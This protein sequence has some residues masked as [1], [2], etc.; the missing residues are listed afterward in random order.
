[1]KIFS[2]FLSL[3]FYNTDASWSD[4]IVYITNETV[5]N[6]F[7]VTKPLEIIGGILNG[8]GKNMFT[9]YNEL[10]IRNSSLTNGTTILNFD[11]FKIENCNVTNFVGENGGFLYNKGI[12]EI[13]G[14]FYN[15]FASFGGV[16]YNEGNLRAIGNFEENRC[17]NNGGVIYSNNRDFISGVFKNNVATTGNGAAFYGINSNSEIYGAF[18]NSFAWRGFGGA[19]YVTKSILKINAECT[20]NQ[21]RRGG[22]IYFEESDCNIDG[23]Y[24]SNRGFGLGG[25]LFSANSY[26]EIKG[27]YVSNEAFVG[28][29]IDFT[30]SKSIITNASFSNNDATRDGGALAINSNCEVTVSN[31]LFR[32]NVCEN[33]GGAIFTQ[34]TSRIN[35]KFQK[36]QAQIGGVAYVGPIFDI[37]FEFNIEAKDNVA[38]LGGVFYTEGGNIDFNGTYVNNSALFSGGVVYIQSDTT[39]TCKD[40]YLI[41]NH[42]PKGGTIFILDGV[43]AKI[44]GCNV[45]NNTNDRGAIFV[46]AGVNVNIK[47]M[48]A[49]SNFGNTGGVLYIENGNAVLTNCHFYDNFAINGGAVYL[50][51][52]SV[53]K[54]LSTFEDNGAS[55]NGGVIYSN[56]AKIISENST[57]SNNDGLQGGVFFLDSGKF[58]STSSVYNK[59]SALNG[60][61]FG[62]VNGASISFEKSFGEGNVAINT[63]GVVYYDSRTTRKPESIADI[64]GTDFFG[65]VFATETA[66]ITVFHLTHIEESNKF[67][68]N[69]LVVRSFDALNQ[70]TTSSDLVKFKQLGI[71][72]EA[73]LI[74]GTVNYTHIIRN[75]FPNTTVLIHVEVDE[76]EDEIPIHLQ[77]CLLGEIKNPQCTVCD[78]NN[79]YTFN[80]NNE[81]CDSCPQHVSCDST[82]QTDFPGTVFITEKGF[83]RSGPFSENVR[84]CPF[85]FSCLGD[86][87]LNEKDTSCGGN[88]KGPLC[89]KCIDK[90]ILNR[91]TGKCI[92]CNKR[93]ILTYSLSI[94]LFLILTSFLIYFF[95]RNRKFFLSFK[96]SKIISFLK[97]LLIFWQILGSEYSSFLFIEFPDSYSFVSKYFKISIDLDFTFFISKLC[98]EIS[99]YNELVTS[100][101]TPITIFV[102]LEVLKWSNFL[103]YVIS[104]LTSIF[105]QKSSIIFCQ[106][107]F[108]YFIYTNVSSILFKTFVCDDEF[109]QENNDSFY[110]RKKY[111]AS[112]YSISCKNQKYDLMRVYSI[113]MCFVYPIGIP[114]YF[115]TILF[116]EKSLR[117]KPESLLNSRYVKKQAN[118]FKKYSNIFRRENIFKGEKIKYILKKIG[119][120]IVYTHN[121]LDPQVDHLHF[122][123]A[124]YHPGYWWFECFEC[125]RRLLL[126]S[127]LPS[128]FSNTND[129]L[130]L[131]YCTFMMSV[132]FFIMYLCINPFENKV[133]G[134]FAKITQGTISFIL[135]L[136]I[137]LY[138]DQNLPSDD[139]SQWTKKQKGYVLTFLSAVFI[140]IIFILNIAKDEDIRILFKK[141]LEN[142]K[143]EEIDSSD[144]KIEEDLEN[145][146]G[147]PKIMFIDEQLKSLQIYT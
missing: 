6:D 144:E 4:S 78:A 33:R 79:E 121:K 115:F 73:S 60:G 111:L 21:A 87:N 112:D 8:N 129:Y 92:R 110:F 36:N 134:I 84:R 49:Y 142:N 14:F 58:E 13:S 99:H 114:L 56:D 135:L 107:T 91:S 35:G 132:F 22:A 128:I 72:A 125:M 67:F 80:S 30:N 108:I 42:G 147:D 12:A 122:L 23:L 146:E 74:K 34:G 17:E 38:A 65:N 3:L 51:L 105:I 127:L 130:S 50:R 28:G 145:Q 139:K 119:N 89:A 31:S 86:V 95:Y 137:F 10:I 19:I 104:R 75:S 43:E 106:L 29:A 120:D 133:V 15:N 88:H 66:K 126:S 96:E 76:F 70:P 52:G 7:N 98:I 90:L 44:D 81:I 141:Y 5:V 41:N 62:L 40:S 27:Q 140:P 138:V 18:E 116:S 124:D 46:S 47:N 82:K 59:N 61:I 77:D 32:N 103:K 100:T 118:E 131:L 123:F 20:N 57:Y 83:W 63:G 39:L 68:K 97:I 117:I 55:Q 54:Y 25:A 93:S 94:L 9:I 45:F 113:L 26:S 2:L 143:D 71:T 85:F 109:K 24:V 1:M 53:T 16:V 102:F 48:V 101:L 136:T 69:P 37:L 11:F 64:S